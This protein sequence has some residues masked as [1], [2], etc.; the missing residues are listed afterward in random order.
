[1]GTGGG[2]VPVG[3]GAESAGNGPGS[4]I[5]ELVGPTGALAQGESVPVGADGVAAAGLAVVLARCRCVGIRLA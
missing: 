1:M 4:A 2:P 5:G 3:G